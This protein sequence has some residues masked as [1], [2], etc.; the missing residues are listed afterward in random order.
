LNGLRLYF[1]FISLPYLNLNVLLFLL[2]YSFILFFIF[3]FQGVF[4]IR[5]TISNLIFF[6][7]TTPFYV[8]NSG[9]LWWSSLCAYF[10]QLLLYCRVDCSSLFCVV[11]LLVG[12]IETFKRC[13]GILFC[14]CLFYTLDFIEIYLAMLLDFCSIWDF[15]KWLY[16]E[17]VFVHPPLFDPDY[18]IDPSRAF[19]HEF[20]GLLYFFFPIYFSFGFCQEFPTNSLTLTP[21]NPG[22]LCPK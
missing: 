8:N 12:S 20:Q 17:M 13:W 16:L 1:H 22:F 9:S 10:L 11:K 18:W 2:F 5:M 15:F 3:L 14:I 4:P 19:C 7:L 6:L 21:V